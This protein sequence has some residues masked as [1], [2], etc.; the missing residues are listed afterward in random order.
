VV[1]KAFKILASKLLFATG[2]VDVTV[3]GCF[4]PSNR[5]WKTTG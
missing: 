3:G 1:V 2:A 4:N 5:S